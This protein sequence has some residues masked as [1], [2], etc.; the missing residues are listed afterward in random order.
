[1]LIEEIH[2]GYERRKNRR[3]YMVR[4]LVP[5]MT[6]GGNLGSSFSFLRFGFLFLEI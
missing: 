2:E 6:Y 3:Q 1:M 5:H 4:L